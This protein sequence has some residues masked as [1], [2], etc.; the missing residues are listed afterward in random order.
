MKKSHL[1]NIIDQE[2]LD[3]LYGFCYRRTD[4]S[5]KAE[6]LCSDIVYELIKTANTEGEIGTDENG[7]VEAL[8][9][10][11]WRVARNVYADFADHRRRE[12]SR[13]ATGDTEAL[14]TLLSDEDDT[15][16]LELLRR[17]A[18]YLSRIYR[19][20]ANLSRAYREVMIAFYLDGKSTRDIAAAQGVSENTIRQRLFSARET[21]RKEVTTMEKTVETKPVALHHLELNLWGHGDP[22]TGDP[23]SLIERQFSRHIL[24]LCRNKEMSA[25]E[26]AE[27][28]NVPMVYVE[29]ELNLQVKGVGETGYGTLRKLPNGKYISNIAMLTK[30]EFLAGRAIYE[31]HY[32]DLCREI[33]NYLRT[34]SIAR[35]Y[36]NFPYLNRAPELYLIWWQHLPVLAYKLG[37]M[38]NELLRDKYFADV[39]PAERPFHLYGSE[40]SET[41]LDF[42]GWDGIAGMNICGYRQVGLENLYTRNLKAHFHCGHNIATDGK[43]QLAIRAIDGLP[44]SALTEDERETAAKA[45]ECG[46]LMRVHDEEH[47]EDMLYTKI[48][49][50]DEKDRE[51][52]YLLDHPLRERLQPLAEQV[53]EQTAAWL[54]KSLPEHLLPEYP[55]VST[56]ASAG[57]F[58]A[59]FHH[60]LDCGLLELPENGL[61]AEGCWMTV[62]K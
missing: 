44:V 20:I 45:I 32:P 51:R 28:L 38:V 9:A 36:I 26:I 31:A 19:Q 21:V 50:M 59:V 15:E 61:G 24:W 17:D 54:R 11:I 27:E 1:L 56:L 42:C 49:V 48:L 34:P 30:E 23:R 37:D 3:K 4:N 14:L 29:E 58:D 43:I 18:V 46:Y 8:Y 6:E 40:M 62:E 22:T 41:H 10:F 39:K 16:E 55:K 7:D 47:T 25:R 5:H 60:L 53:A 57:V 13:T 52:V 35:Q 2:L 12:I 33:T